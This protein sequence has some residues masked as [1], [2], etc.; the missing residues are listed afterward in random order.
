MASQELYHI[1]KCI[2]PAVPDCL[3]QVEPE[4]YEARWWKPV[5]TIDLEILRHADGVAVLGEPYE[6]HHLPAGIAVRFTINYS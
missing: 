3:E 2:E 1:W 5:P 4:V 6:P